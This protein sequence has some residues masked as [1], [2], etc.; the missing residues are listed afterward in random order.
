MQQE[1]AYEERLNFIHTIA[2][3]AQKFQRQYGVLA[4][5]SMG[6]AAL[7][8]NFGESQLSTEFNNLYG[9]KADEG[10]TDKV[11]FPTLEYVEDEWIE[12]EDWF[13]VYPSWEASIEGHARLIYNGTSWDA[14][15]YQV[16]IDGDTYEEQ[17]SGL[18]EAGYATDPTYADK[19]VEIIEIWD[20]AQYDQP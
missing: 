8:S 18:Q 19:L 9:V 7:E 10:D 2:P 16:V 17:A 11:L 12:I 3:S 15:F 13:K 4:S 5:I 14:D 6:Q 1:M 20:L